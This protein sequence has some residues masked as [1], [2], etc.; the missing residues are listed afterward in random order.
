M[1]SIQ[2]A[3][4]LVKTAFACLLFFV[5]GLSGF[6][7]GPCSTAWDGALA[8]S[9]QAVQVSGFGCRPLIVF[10]E[11]ATNPIRNRTA[12]SPCV[13]LVWTCRGV[14]DIDRHCCFSVRHRSQKK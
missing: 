10:V 1:Y 9:I 2:A 5:V 8:Y 4:V 12:L 3:Q 13:Q 6:L 11:S 14:S 7:A